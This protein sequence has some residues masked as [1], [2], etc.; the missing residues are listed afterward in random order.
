MIPYSI[1][2]GI[3]HSARPIVMVHWCGREMANPNA[4]FSYNSHVNSPYLS[5]NTLTCSFLLGIKTI[6]Y[7]VHILVTTHVSGCEWL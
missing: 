6:N 2:A 5:C 7:H 3:D 1:Q 4:S